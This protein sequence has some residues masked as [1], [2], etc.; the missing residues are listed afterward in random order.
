MG[1]LKSNGE[2]EGIILAFTKKILDFFNYST[3]FFVQ[4]SVRPLYISYHTS[5]SILYTLSNLSYDIYNT[6]LLKGY[7]EPTEIGLRKDHRS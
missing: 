1:L 5:K 3:L 7:L 2:G 6:A 4:F